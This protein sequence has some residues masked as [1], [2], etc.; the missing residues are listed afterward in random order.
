MPEELDKLVVALQQAASE[1]G[2]FVF[3]G[4]PDVTKLASVAW[5]GDWLSFLDLAQQARA[6]LL[7]IRAHR[8][9][10]NQVIVEESGLFRTCRTTNRGLP[11]Q[12]ALEEFFPFFG[13]LGHEALSAMAF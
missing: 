11:H 2:L 12:K 10:P 4:E 3:D 9:D 1:R 5:G 8:Y 13:H 6:H 7:Y